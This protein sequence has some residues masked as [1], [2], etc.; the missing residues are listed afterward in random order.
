MLIQ[1]INTSNSELDYIRLRRIHKFVPV[2]TSIENIYIYIY[3]YI[4]IKLHSL[5]QLFIKFLKL[6]DN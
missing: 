6:K 4:Y 5:T 1:L 3:I 2:R